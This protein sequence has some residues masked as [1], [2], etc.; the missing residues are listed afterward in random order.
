MNLNEISTA[1]IAVLIICVGL[2]VYSYASNNPLDSG[3]IYT[4]IAAIAGLAGYDLGR[5]GK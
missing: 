1:T 2:Y 4:A 5:G 3:L